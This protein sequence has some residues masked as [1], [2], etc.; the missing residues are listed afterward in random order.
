MKRLTMAAVLVLLASA[1]LAAEAQQPPTYTWDQGTIHAVQP[2]SAS[3]E[4]V[5]GVGM[6][7]RLLRL[8]AS[9]NAQ[10]AG[11]GAALTDLKRGDICRALCY[12]SDGKLFADRIEKVVQ[13]SQE[14]DHDLME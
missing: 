7:L 9:H 2:K 13:V 12:A 10:V 1:L 14:A 5:T 3:F 8:L 6:S 4:M 11:G